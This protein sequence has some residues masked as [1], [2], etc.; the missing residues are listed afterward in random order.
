MILK[1]FC[2]GSSS[3]LRSFRFV[4]F[5]FALLGAGL[6][7]LVG[8]LFIGVGCWGS[9]NAVDVIVNLADQAVALVLA[10]LVVE[11]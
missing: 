7:R 5:F 1:G 4:A 10:F 9:D 8:F 3:T 11:G 2:F 6:M